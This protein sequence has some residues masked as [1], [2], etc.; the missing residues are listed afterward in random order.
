MRVV[1]AGV[2]VFGGLFALVAVAGAL[3]VFDYDYEPVADDKD[4]NQPRAFPCCEF[5][6][7]R[8]KKEGYVAEVR[9]SGS[10]RSSWPLQRHGW[11]SDR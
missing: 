2:F 7:R 4:V 6:V 3:G 1:G 9:C 11:Q 10:G 8:H 5:T